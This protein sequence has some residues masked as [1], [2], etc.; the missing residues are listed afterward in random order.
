MKATEFIP[1][2]TNLLVEPTKVEKETSSGIILQSTET[3]ELPS[4]GKVIK[5]DTSIPVGATVFFGKY[6][7]AI[8][9]LA[10]T[11]YHI[12]KSEDIYGYCN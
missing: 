8:I 1:T 9:K 4:S 5:S 7:G 6:S 3:K 2:N 12:L 10:D 11:E